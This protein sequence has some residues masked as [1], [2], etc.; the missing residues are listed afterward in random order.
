MLHFSSYTKEIEKEII[1]SSYLKGINLARASGKIKI[2]QNKF[3]FFINA[4]AV[5]IF[6]LVS[7]WSQNIK[8]ESIFKNKSL[9]SKLYESDDARGDKKGHMYINYFGK[10]PQI[11]SA[12]PDPRKDNR[13]EKI[14]NNLLKNTVDPVTGIFNL[15]LYGNC[16]NKEFIYDGKRKYALRSIYINKENII[17]NKFYPKT[18]EAI[19]C[20]FDI[21]KLQGYTNKEKK[22]YPKNG[23]VWFKK[24][25]NNLFFPVKFEVRTSWGVFLCL[26]KEKDF[27]YESN[28]M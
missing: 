15:G 13:R 11:I 19:K 5:G 10:Y 18:F 3:S 23:F 20:S 26:I 17:S 6:S 21:E 22:K 2:D 16:N 14:N 28:S 25:D 9:T 4:K 1:L 8:T 7:N 12:Q 24:M 27:N